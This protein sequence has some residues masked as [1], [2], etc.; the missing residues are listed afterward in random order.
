[1][2]RRPVGDVGNQARA[3]DPDGYE[4]GQQCAG[5][6]HEVGDEAG[7]HGQLELVEGTLKV[8]GRKF[9]IG[10]S[11]LYQNKH[12]ASGCLGPTFFHQQWLATTPE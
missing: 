5:V 1:M 4:R 8:V 6:A 3:L 7:T 12:V 10:G 9:K 11:C 2:L